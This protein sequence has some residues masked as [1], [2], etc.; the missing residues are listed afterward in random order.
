MST[1]LQC[2]STLDDVY[3]LAQDTSAALATILEWRNSFVRVN[4]IPLDVLSLI[5][6]HLPPEDRLRATFV[7]RHWRKVF[8]QRAELWSEL[9]LGKSDY[10]HV[11]TLLERAKGCA[12][13][14]TVVRQVP[15]DVIRL[16]APHAQK[17]KF[18]RFT[19]R[20][21]KEAQRF[22]RSDF[23]SFSSLHTLTLDGVWDDFNEAGP[24]F[25]FS[26]MTN[27]KGFRFYPEPN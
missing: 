6:T 1:S 5:P 8:L 23:P 20:G 22:S 26:K 7:C 14:V 16:I 4:R 15:R 18:L 27:I 25:A 19:R 2:S 11:E 17:I 12:L 3:R 9:H 21:L 13:D 10:D 24:L